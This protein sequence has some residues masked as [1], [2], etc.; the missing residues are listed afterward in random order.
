MTITPFR[1]LNMRL[2]L[3]CCSLE[4]LSFQTSWIFLWIWFSNTN[5]TSAT[6]MKVI[7]FRNL[8]EHSLDLTTMRP[9]I[10]LLSY[11]LKVTLITDGIVTKT[12]LSHPLKTWLFLISYPMKLNLRFSH[13]LLTV[14]F[15]SALRVSLML[16]IQSIQWAV[17]IKM[18]TRF[19]KDMCTLNG[20]TRFIK[21]LC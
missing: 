15:W 13:N 11:G 3:S 9:S 21:T 20:R 5:N 14:N 19:G 12:Q 10:D 2:E 7:N 8:L 1:T 18:A 4:F 17:Q 6:L 16:R